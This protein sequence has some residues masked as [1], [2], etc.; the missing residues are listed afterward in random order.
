MP[1]NSLQELEEIGCGISDREKLVKEQM[2]DPELA[3]LAQETVAD[4]VA[5]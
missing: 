4:E 5:S 1:H 2:K 3:R